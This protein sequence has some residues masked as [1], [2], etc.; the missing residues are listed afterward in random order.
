MKRG[1]RRWCELRT[2]DKNATRGSRADA[3]FFD[4]LS[5]W[6]RR[7][8][9]AKMVRHWNWPDGLST[10]IEAVAG[11]HADYLVR[12][13][14]SM[15]FIFNDEF[16]RRECPSLAD[17]DDTVAPLAE[18][19]ASRQ[20]WHGLDLRLAAMIEWWLPDDLLHKADRMTM[21]HSLELRCPFLDADFARYCASLSLDEKALPS[22]G[23]A[24]R[25]VALK[26]AFSELLPE[27][28]DRKSTRL[29]SSHLGISYAVFC[30]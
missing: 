11:S 14:A 7:R 12:H 6:S 1:S 15:S 21:A 26:R 9:L 16:R 30:L 5:R 18:F 20:G 3:G 28:I 23:E 29:N 17:S 27:G 2:R 19:F 8:P 10:R 25:K 22:T 4:R 13:P 24:H